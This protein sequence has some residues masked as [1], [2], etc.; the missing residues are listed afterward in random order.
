MD[1]LYARGIAPA[2][3][4]HAERTARNGHQACQRHVTA[5]T[6][7]MAALRERGMDDLYARGVRAH[8]QSAADLKSIG[9][10]CLY[11]FVTKRDTAVTA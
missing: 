9:Q 2:L 3:Y 5:T 1:D 6:E 7:M 4:P 11:S 8:T 10:K